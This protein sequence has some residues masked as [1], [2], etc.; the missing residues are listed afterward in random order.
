MPWPHTSETRRWTAACTGGTER[1]KGKEICL[2]LITPPAGE[3]VTLG[4][5]KLWS[6]VD[7]SDYIPDS[8]HWPACA[9]KCRMSNCSEST[10]V[11]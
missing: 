4:E 2:T 3:P 11:A 1:R 7:H 9:A 10:F 5:M 8:T 6:R